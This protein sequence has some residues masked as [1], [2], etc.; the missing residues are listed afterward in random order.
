MRSSGEPLA[1]GLQDLAAP[2]RIVAGVDVRRALDLR[3]EAE[4]GRD[5]VGT[6]VRRDPYAGVRGHQQPVLRIDERTAPVIRHLEA[7]CQDDRVGRTRLLAQAAEDAAQFVDL[8][9][10]RV[11]LAGRTAVV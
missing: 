11:A 8:V 4:V 1:F 2:G 10:S 6:L 9:T 7:R 3:D 5:A